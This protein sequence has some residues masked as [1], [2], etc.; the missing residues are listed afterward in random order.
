MGDDTI[1]Q[2]VALLLAELNVEIPKEEPKLPS[3]PDLPMPKS[4]PSDGGKP[5]PPAGDALV[6]AQEAVRAKYK[7]Q[8]AAAVFESD[9]AA[10]AEK[11]QEAAIDDGDAAAKYALLLEARDLAAAGQ[12]PKL[13]LVIVTLIDERFTIDALAMKIDALAAAQKAA[14]DDATA[15]KQVAEE[16]MTLADEAALLEKY[17]QASRL[18]A[19]AVQTARKAKDPALLKDA[20]ERDKQIRALKPS[21]K[22]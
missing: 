7:Q 5:K 11:L 18:A 13:A 3:V 19:M 14:A 1:K 4:E 9:K 21:G 16:A 22:T 15:N 8:L 17:P 10:L 6:K 20:N 2:T 12:N